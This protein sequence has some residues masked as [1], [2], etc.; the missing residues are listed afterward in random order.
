MLKG[1]KIVLG[2]TGGIAAYKSAELTRLL[3]KEGSD[4]RIIMTAHAKEFITPLTLSTLSGNP[5]YCDTF[6]LT[7]EW[8]I[9]HISLAEY[10]DL[11]II[12]P[13]TA[14]IIG[15]IASGMADDLLSTTVMA[16][17]APILIC[18]AMNTNM[19]ENTIVQSNI[20]KLSSL[21]YHFMDAEKGE[22]ACR[23]E[24][25]GRL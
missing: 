20:G 15:K 9:G 11:M 22:L 3:V 10:A 2:V 25:S 17:K 7:G 23:T 5:I 8:K 16:T 14:N 19:Y 1:K 12:A 6:S 24:G 4:V 18:P 13:A 21:G